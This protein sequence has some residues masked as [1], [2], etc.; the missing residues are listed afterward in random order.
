MLKSI[1][2]PNLIYLTSNFLSLP[3]HFK[4]AE[5]SIYIFRRVAKWAL[6][7]SCVEMNNVCCPFWCVCES[8]I[9]QCCVLSVGF[10]CQYQCVLF[11]ALYVVVLST[12]CQIVLRQCC[13][14]LLCVTEG[15]CYVSAM[16][17]QH[18]M[19]VCLTTGVIKITDGYEWV[20]SHGRRCVV[21]VPSCRPPFRMHDSSETV[22]LSL[23]WKPSLWIMDL[24]CV[25]LLWNKI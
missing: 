19:R 15:S 18:C 20:L 16:Y 5:S 23:S 22:S 13:F 1:H 17:H 24:L 14:Y 3:F 7:I 25:K 11:V 12:F 9:V 10:V 4:I 2:I 6:L 8:E 21:P